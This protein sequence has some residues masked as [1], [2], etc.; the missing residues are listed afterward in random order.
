M[1]VESPVQL[2]VVLDGVDRAGTEAT[3]AELDDEFV[4]GAHLVAK[5]ERQSAIVGGALFRNAEDS[6]GSHGTPLQET[7]LGVGLIQRAV[8]LQSIEP[9]N[10]L[11]WRLRRFF[12][13]CVL[14]VDRIERARSRI[15]RHFDRCR[16]GHEQ[17]KQQW[18]GYRASTGLRHRMILL[19][20]S[21][22]GLFW[23][24]ALIVYL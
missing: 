3:V 14:P 7:G 9:G 20:E 13:G 23:Y 16:K 2:D 10:R 17:R 11:R 5:L 8:D 12:S 4:L 15:G 1:L 18:S 22:D 19:L 6:L 24:H 21:E